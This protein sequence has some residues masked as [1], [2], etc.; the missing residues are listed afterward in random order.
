MKHQDM[1]LRVAKPHKASFDYSVAFEKGD[2]VKVGREDPEMPSWY[3]CMNEDGVWSWVPEEY[4]ERKGPVGVIT[5]KYDTGEL[6]VDKGEILEY[7][8]EVHLWTL[9]RAQDGR[10]GWV[11]TANLER[12]Q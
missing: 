10:L 11:P 12:D 9:C 6:T 5:Q 1:Y 3:W 7:V 8:T 4:L 2:V